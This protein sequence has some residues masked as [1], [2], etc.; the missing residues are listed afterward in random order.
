MEEKIGSL[1]SLLFVAGDEGLTLEEMT[2]LLEITPLEAHNLVSLLKQAYEQNQGSGLTII[3][4]RNRYQL[5][6]KRQ[7]S[8]LIKQYAVSPFTSH[9]SQAALETLAIIAYKQPI[10]RIE[11][12]E[13]RGVQSSSMLQ[14]LI[15]RGLVKDLG[16][17]ETPGRPI[18]YGTSEYF[19]NYFGLKDLDDLP[20]AEGLFEM[21][22]DE[23]FDLFDQEDFPIT[24]EEG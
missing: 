5:A 16:R 6:T 17:S 21:A 14:R 23:F 11:I 22:E 4:T 7:Y 12:D 20:N 15:L 13:I 24:E 8:E 19:M 18:N 2:A 1:E 3:E 10:T 9:L